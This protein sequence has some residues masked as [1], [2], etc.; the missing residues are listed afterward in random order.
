MDPE[1]QPT[2]KLIVTGPKVEPKHRG[3]C[4]TSYEL[5]ESFFETLRQTYPIKYMVIG[6]ETCPSTQRKHLQ[7]YMYF[8]NPR[9]LAG[10]KRIMKPRH[11]EVA[12]GD[13]TENFEY[14]SKEREFKEWGKRPQ[15]GERT[16]LEMIQEMI[17]KNNEPQLNIADEYFS[18]WCQYGARFEKYRALCR[19]KRNWVT[20]VYIY[21]GAPGNGKTRKART[22][23]PNIVPVIMNGDINAPFVNGYNGEDEVLFDDFEPAVCSRAYMLKLLDRY[24]MEA[25]IKGGSI[26]WAPKVVIFTTNHDPH[27]WYC[28]DGAFRRRVLAVEKITTEEVYM[29]EAM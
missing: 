18:R 17:K 15:Q 28:E 21:W 23:F 22:R 24:P 14:C 27:E 5:D 4:F 11:V 10:V 7:G 20:E 2:P 26:N 1:T 6:K 25:N 9:G 12:K 29:A 8:T 13:A 3:F 16:D 19:P